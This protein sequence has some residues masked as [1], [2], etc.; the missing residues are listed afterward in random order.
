MPAATPIA[1]RRP[2]GG[3]AG[4]GGDDGRRLR[5]L[6]LVAWLSPALPT[7]GFAYSHGLETAVAAG[8]VTS[9]GQLRDWIAT[10]LS[11]G[12]GRSDAILL[13]HAWRAARDGDQALADRVAALAD[14]CRA[15]H[16]L[17]L[18]SR[19]QGEAFLVAVAEGW[20][21]PAIDRYR[22]RLA[23]LGRPPAY[24]AAVGVVTQ[25]AGIA[26]GDAVL[27]WLQAFAGSLL[28]AGIKLIPL[29]QRAGLVVQARLEPVILAAAA[30][31][32]QQRLDDLAT[33]AWVADW[34]SAA[35][36]TDYTRLFRS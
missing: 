30:A 17:A 8:L 20:A 28:A 19:A 6:R 11:D 14:A 29:G 34:A 7:G 10:T 26:L 35:H 4:D 24:A 31:A 13:C 18:E 32:E 21:L 33:A 3:D 25:A 23:E 1:D 2:G 27:A 22:A 16:E 36:E 15:T 12:G 5:L 9:A